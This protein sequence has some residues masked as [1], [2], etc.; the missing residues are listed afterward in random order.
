MLN[1]I[2]MGLTLPDI[3]NTYTAEG[4][5]TVTCNVQECPFR[6]F[7]AHSV[8][9]DQQ[10]LG[11]FPGAKTILNGAQIIQCCGGGILAAIRSCSGNSMG[12][13]NHEAIRNTEGYTGIISD[14]K[15]KALLKLTGLSLGLNAYYDF[16]HN[17]PMVPSTSNKVPGVPVIPNRILEAL[18]QSPQRFSEQF[19]RRTLSEMLETA[20]AGCQR[21][22]ERFFQMGTALVALIDP[23][24]VKINAQRK[25]K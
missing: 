3:T 8:Y 13:L 25:S 19:I 6:P 5:P 11:A 15:G 23:A 24:L 2:I 9:S 18:G 4:N 10:D 17:T 21:P 22:S 16:Y 1:L 14:P 7:L 12:L 20:Y